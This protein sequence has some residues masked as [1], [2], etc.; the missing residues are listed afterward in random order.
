MTL[1]RQHD[2][3][4]GLMAK[5][6]RTPSSDRRPTSI[7]RDPWYWATAI[8]LSAVVVYLN[9]IGNEFVLDD[10]RIIAENLRI[11]SLSNIPA[12]FIS[13]Y[14]DVAGTQGLYRPL[15]L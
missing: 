11:R 15:A 1:R 7:R 3:E 8:G 13:P 10:T 5:K 14:W 9:A 2:A 12:L 6:K 4:Q